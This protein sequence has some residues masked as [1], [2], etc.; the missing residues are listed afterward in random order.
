MLD[1]KTWSLDWAGHKLVLEIGKFANQADAS[2]VCRY[3]GTEVMATVVQA[4]EPREEVDYF[5]LMVDY[6]ERLYAAGKIK[7]S[8]FIKREGRP[9]DEAV[10]IARMVDRTIRPLFNTN[11]RLDVQVILTVFSIDEENSPDIPCLI[12]ASCALSCSQLDWQGPV[13]G[14]RVGLVND[15][16]VLNPSYAQREGS[17]L[18]LIVCTTKESKT[19]MLEA[20]AAE[21]SKEEILKAVA[22][23]KKSNQ[24]VIDFISEIKQ[25]VVANLVL[26]EKVKKSD[27]DQE[28]P[29]QEEYLEL[30]KEF[31]NN[32]LDEYLFNQP[33]ATKKERLKTLEKLKK[34]LDDYLIKKQV[35][36]EKREK[37]LRMIKEKV[38][39]IVSQAILE[40]EQR[41]DQRKLDE[42]RPLNMDVGIFARTHG[43]AHFS[44]G[45]TQVVSVVTLGSP[46]DVQYLDT[47]ETEAKKRYMHHYNFPPYSVGEVQP[48]RGPGRREIGHGALAEKALL[49]VLPDQA[50]FPYTIRVVSEV[51]SS[52]GSS[53]MASTCGSSLALMDAG[54]PI[55]RPVAGIA[56][57]LVS[58]QGDKFKIIT[59]LQDLEDGPGG[60]DFKICAT[61]CGIT[62]LQM[63]TKTKGL[64]DKIITQALKQGMIAI[65]E[66]LDQMKNVINKPR[67]E[68]CAYAP[69]IYSLKVD[70]EKIGLIIGPQG[71]TIN[72]I[73]ERT[74][75]EIDIEKDGTVMIT[76]EDKKS[77]EAAKAE[78]KEIIREL[79]IGEVYQG[80]VSRILD[81]GAIVEIG[82]AQDGF[83]H[84]SNLSNNYVKNVSDVVAVGDEL[85]VK[86]L[87][88]EPNGKISLA[89]EGVE[90]EKR[91]QYSGRKEKRF[92]R[93]R[94]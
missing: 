36:K 32:N 67:A 45:E 34:A 85:K 76:A 88:K 56:I 11:S 41:L 94:Y 17:A 16:L 2:C 70:P 80:R 72:G 78:V 81:S 75:V 49:P 19:I 83:V 89:V 27:V 7:G 64:S 69:R 86:V 58:G 35:G 30:A 77:L 50:D 18:D 38:E 53:S 3:G 46:G 31:L 68:L 92:N 71:K 13:A 59:D 90:T 44:R 25:K 79:K 15:K 65:K 63:D 93:R 60:M 87:A 1:K 62:A 22:L 37:A 52:N 54:V 5:P 73:I 57:G 51:L 12:A 40:K 61:D 84:V 33:K 9:S 14:L 26:T 48:L 29:D 39:I 23:A 24:L 8:R 74:G 20:G 42:I 6:E 47:M 4:D 10:L 43:S 91:K 82:P 28:E 66:I 21:V 55:K